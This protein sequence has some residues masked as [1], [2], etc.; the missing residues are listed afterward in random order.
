MPAIRRQIKKITYAIIYAVLLVLVLLLFIV[1]QISSWRG[2]Q[3]D[4]DPLPTASILVES[5]DAVTHQDTVDIVARIRNPNPRDGVPRYT[6]VFVLVNK[7]GEEIN[8]IPKQTYLLPGSLNYI[9]TLDVPLTSALD[10]VKLETTEEPVFAKLSVSDAVPNFNSFLREREI[11]TFGADRFEIQKGLVSNRSA[12]GYRDVDV[13]G[14]AFDAAG[15][16]VGVS[17][18]FI[19]EFQVG[20]QRE[21]TLQWPAPRTP[22]QRVIVLPSANIYEPDNILD[23]V[24]DPDRLREPS[25]VSEDSA[26]SGPGEEPGLTL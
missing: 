20:D 14:V 6:V 17:T 3:A 21:F 2:D 11:R 7:Q 16:V 19:G 9:A 8:R 18:T 13:T 4:S 15:K 5:I 10:K 23:V 22:T 1:P 24:G 12:L 26:E 25:G